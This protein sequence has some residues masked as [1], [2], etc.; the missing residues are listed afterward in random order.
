MHKHS[1]E[2]MSQ[3][4]DHGNQTTPTCQTI[5]FEHTNHI[6]YEKQVLEKI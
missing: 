4:T 6:T 1:D 2:H 3:R 5:Y